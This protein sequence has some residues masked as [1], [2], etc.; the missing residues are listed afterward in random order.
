MGLILRELADKIQKS[1]E[2]N[3]RRKHMK[4]KELEKKIQKYLYPVCMTLTT[5]LVVLIVW[6]TLADF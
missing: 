3:E 2:P 5:I 4:N 6:V 1:P